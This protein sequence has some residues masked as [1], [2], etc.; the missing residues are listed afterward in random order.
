MTLYHDVI[1]GVPY[2]LKAPFDFSF[3]S[4]CGK[5]FKVFD[6]QDSGNICFGAS[7]GENKYFI[8]FAG[9]PTAQS[10]ISPEEAIKRTKNTVQI[11]RDLEHPTLTKLIDADEIGGGFAIVF[12]W[13]EGDCMGR[14]YPES[15]ARF[16]Q[17]PFDIRLRVFDDIFAFHAYAAKKNY[18]AIDFYDG[19]II[20]DPN[21][22]RTVI[23]D[24]E[25]YSKSPYINNMGR[26]WGSSRFMSPEEF[27]PGAVIDEITNVYT[28]GATAFA[29]FSDSDRSLE[30]W[31][32]S[33]GLYLIV[34]KAVNN[35]RSDRQQ[36]IEQF[37]TEWNGTK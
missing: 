25:C 8:K 1:D 9:A 13:I 14:Q 24:I 6:D 37:I 28:M 19:C 32:L 18:A 3:L 35:Q 20:Y 5:V 11:Y 16:M 26:M 22:N 15:R 23:C 30:K 33:Q 29:L 21:I 7:D 17:L 10:H 27:Q 34:K 36:S 12:E 4:K 31:P 2:K